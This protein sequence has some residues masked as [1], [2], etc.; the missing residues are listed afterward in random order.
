MSLNDWKTDR[1]LVVDSNT[2]L[3]GL[4]GGITRKLLLESD[5]KLQYPA[6]SFDE[7][8]RNRGV[9]QER[10]NLSATTIDTL[11]ETIFKN[12]SLVPKSQ[13]IQYREEA[14]TAKSPHPD[15]NP[16]RPFIERDENDMVFLAATMAVDGDIWSDD[17]V[18]KHHTHGHKYVKT[19]GTLIRLSAQRA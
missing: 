4:V 13:V 14:M 6:Q 7:I 19:S 17:G 16:E 8:E 1:P 15:A 5:R 9:I 18:F 2:V 10:S 11:L 12:I 3:S